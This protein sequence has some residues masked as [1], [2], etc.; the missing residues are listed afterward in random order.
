MCDRCHL[1]IET[2]NTCFITVQ[3]WKPDGKRIV[4]SSWTP[5]W[6]ST[7]KKHSLSLSTLLLQNRNVTQAS[8][9]S[10]PSYVRWTG[11]NRTR[12]CTRISLDIYLAGFFLRTLMTTSNRWSPLANPPRNRD[13]FTR[14]LT[15]LNLPKIVSQYW[16]VIG[17]GSL[18]EWWDT[19]RLTLQN[20]RGKTRNLSAAIL[21]YKLR[22]DKRGPT[23][24]FHSSLCF[25]PRWLWARGLASG[26]L[27]VR[28]YVTL[29]LACQGPLTWV[30]LTRERTGVPTGVSLGLEGH[31]GTRLSWLRLIGGWPLPPPRFGGCG[32]FGRT[33]D[34][35]L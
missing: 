29:E 12:M 15:N 26:Q 1:K 13:S 9:F 32:L 22:I 31:F 21:D 24:F 10:S 20:T 8:S 7:W 23:F 6:W 27:F 16:S 25:A 18:W 4:A 5:K 19:T 14:S 28:S 11:T 17:P 3:K 30:V 33:S 35:V 2:Q 34:F